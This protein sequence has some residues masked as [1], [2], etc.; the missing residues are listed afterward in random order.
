MVRGHADPK[1]TQM[2]AQTVTNKTLN[3]IDDETKIFQGKIKFKQY[4]S[5]NPVLQRILDRE[6]QHKEGT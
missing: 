1:R 3:H 2:P 5:I 6:L 4:L